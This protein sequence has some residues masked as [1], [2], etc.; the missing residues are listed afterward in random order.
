MSKVILD[1]KIENID[2]RFAQI[3]ETEDHDIYEAVIDIPYIPENTNRLAFRFS[4][5]KSDGILLQNINEVPEDS[6]AFYEKYV[7]HED[8]DL[9]RLHPLDWNDQQMEIAIRKLEEETESQLNQINIKEDIKKIENPTSE[10]YS[11]ISSDDELVEITFSEE[12]VE[13]VS[14]EKDMTVEIPVSEEQ[15]EIVSDLSSDA[16]QEVPKKRKRRKKKAEESEELI[17]ENIVEVT[18]SEDTS[19]EKTEKTVRVKDPTGIRKR[20]FIVDRIPTPTCS[21][22]VAPTLMATGYENATYKN[23]YSVGHFPKLGIIE[24]WEVPEETF[25]EETQMNVDP[26]QNNTESGVFV[27]EDAVHT[28]AETIANLF[29]K[30]NSGEDKEEVNSLF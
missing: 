14:V 9:S 15:K 2:D 24:I 26:N 22:N 6:E 8:V 5:R 19:E 20:G 12:S 23:F 21:G 27:P 17:C 11:D 4:I 3:L 10:E 29:S 7:N 28:S 16:E 13:R 30:D 25:S 18:E 1:G